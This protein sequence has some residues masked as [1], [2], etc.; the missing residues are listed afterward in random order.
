MDEIKQ[1]RVLIAESVADDVQRIL[2]AGVYREF[3]R[4]CQGFCM[5]GVSSQVTYDREILD[6]LR[7]PAKG[8][9]VV[10]I[11]PQVCNTESYAMVG[12]LREDPLI[13]VAINLMQRELPGVSAAIA[14]LR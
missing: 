10:G 3:R 4:I 9:L 14:A 11:L 13:I 1:V 8:E 7:D 5:G 12:L 6:E 2:D